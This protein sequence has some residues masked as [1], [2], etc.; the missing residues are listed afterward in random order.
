MANPAGTLR[1]DITANTASLRAGF[2]KATAYTKKFKRDAN[3]SFASVRKAVF[4][5]KSALF[6]M[7]G[8]AGLGAVAKS[9]ITAASTSEQY[10]V[11]LK[12][13]L[14]SV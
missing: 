12:V 14:G 9:F 8:V 13:M 11:R 7:A 5:L 2:V 3:K 4:S 1:V 6:G 10:R